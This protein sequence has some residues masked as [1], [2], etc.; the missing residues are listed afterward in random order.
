MRRVLLLHPILRPAGGGTAVAVWTIQAL[1]RDHRVH[2]VTWD[3][4]DVDAV[5][6]YYG[7]SLRRGDF[8]WQAAP[9]A[10][11]WLARLDRDPASI[12]RACL[13]LRT[14]KRIRHRFDIVL[15]T[16][17]EAD[18]GG[19]GIQYVHYPWWRD[20]YAALHPREPRSLRER[21]V[22]ELR[23]RFR[24]WWWTSGFSFERMKRN[25]TLV[26]SHW[27]A[28][29]V[30]TAYGIEADVVYPPVPGGFPDVPWEV[31]QAGFVCIGRIAREK[32]IERVVE[33]L[34]AVRARGHDVHLHMIGAPSDTPAERSYCRELRSRLQPY[35]SWIEWEGRVPRD[36][37][38]RLVAGHRYGIHA[39]P[40]E[41][42]GIAVAEMMRGG[43]VPFVPSGGGQVEIVGGDPRV[44]YD[45]VDDAVDRICA[46]LEDPGG[47]PGLRRELAR[48]AERFG[49]EPFTRRIREIVEAHRS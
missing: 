46:V 32:N 2:V 20:L 40:E 16:D 28:D 5:N 6:R 8:T 18:L 22:S 11:R 1:C 41:H 9:A 42:F 4:V 49:T 30:R 35:R 15:S 17:Q 38:V 3:P 36:E 19:P 45:S 31:R 29:Q 47:R 7:T 21:V 34:G 44:V 23:Y 39:M 13:L 10:L 24:P 33:I 27:T 14:V 48:R 25:R 37:L 12:Q 26:N 43:C